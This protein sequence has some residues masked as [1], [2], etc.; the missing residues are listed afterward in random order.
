MQHSLRKQLGGP[1]RKHVEMGDSRVDKNHD[2]FNQKIG[3][4]CF[5]SDFL[6]TSDFFGF[7]DFLI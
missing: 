6:F 1:R 3:F 2:F 7:Y 5:E 4:F